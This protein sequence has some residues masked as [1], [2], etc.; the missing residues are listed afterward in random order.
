MLLTEFSPAIFLPSVYIPDIF[1]LIHLYLMI[2]Y[3]Q[4]LLEKQ[5][6]AVISKLMPA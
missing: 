6:V 1:N 2:F 5:I 3:P 4:V